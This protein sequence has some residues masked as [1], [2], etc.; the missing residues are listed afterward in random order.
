MPSLFLLVNI[1]E[2]QSINAKLV[3]PIIRIGIVVYAFT[4]VWATF[5]ETAVTD[6]WFH[7]AK[8]LYIKQIV[9]IVH[10]STSFGFYLTWLLPVTFYWP[11]KSKTLSKYQI[12]KTSMTVSWEINNF[13]FIFF[14]VSGSFTK[15]YIASLC[16][17]FGPCGLVLTVTK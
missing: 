10:Q 12:I 3:L 7:D 2:P 9:L 11:K 14:K 13:L 8:I 17:L 1:H 6:A 4:L 5:V 16:S 15:K